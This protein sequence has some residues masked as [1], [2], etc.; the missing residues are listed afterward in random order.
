M[1][2]LEARMLSAGV[3]PSTVVVTVSTI[4]GL[5]RDGVDWGTVDGPALVQRCAGQPARLHRLR[6]G[7]IHAFSEAEA[8][9]RWPEVYQRVN[10][11]PV[12]AAGGDIKAPTLENS[13]PVAL[14]RRP[15]DDPVRVL[16]GSLFR[17]LLKRGGMTTAS[18]FRSHL[19]FLYGF[20]AAT[21]A[22]L[23]TDAHGLDTDEIQQRLRALDHE[24][25]V[26]AYDRYRQESDR[27]ERRLTLSALCSQLHVLTVVFRDI[28]RVTKGRAIECGDFGVLA[29]RRRKRDRRGANSDAGCSTIGH[30]T[31]ST[32]SVFADEAP[33]AD[34][35][36]AWLRNAGEKKQCGIHCFNA[37][38]TRALY[39]ACET[40]FERLLLTALFTT[41]MRIGGFCLARRQGA[42]Y[43]Q[44]PASVSAGTT[45]S[46]NEKGN[47]PRDYPIAAGLAALLP[48]WVAAGMSGPFY[49]FPSTPGGDRPM[50][51]RV[52]RSA[53]MRVAARADVVGPY[54]HPH[55]TRHTVCWTLSAL[56]NELQYI[57]DFAG[58]KSSAVTDKVYIAMEAAQKR[59]RMVIP[60]LSG[61]GQ[62]ESDRLKAIAWELASAIAG[63]FASP[64][65]RTFPVYTPPPP[66]KRGVL[67]KPTVV[68]LDPVVKDAQHK[69]VAE[70][71]VN[72]AE[73]KAA[74]KAKK[75]EEKE[76]RKER[77]ASVNAEFLEAMKTI[78][79]S[80][81][82]ND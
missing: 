23:I 15:P 46:T 35:G 51:T 60:W 26:R 4:R 16:F 29:P 79:E 69:E 39:L 17:K 49:L 20:M 47:V 37:A 73:E 77:M 58:H 76:R 45:L 40:D 65:G 8:R 10:S 81:K 82:S 55:T 13:L 50:D 21:P 43:G 18:T 52:A 70:A 56:D 66:A 68:V 22:S 75:M 31:A 64:D 59:S 34:R 36:A 5:Q 63:P 62:A 11:R 9:V 44:S 25:V 28:L 72:R 32:L 74:K 1:D 27:V 7:L 14:I 33:I 67:K 53:F 61:T 80:N 48:R 6:A 30:S 41:S 57:A 54:V 2:T 3:K 78:K 38:E 12:P 71:S 24:Q 19:S 42:V